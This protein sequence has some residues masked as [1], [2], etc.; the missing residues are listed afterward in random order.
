MARGNV[1]EVIIKAKDIAS[2]VVGRFR[3]TLRGIT[4]TAK[5]VARGIAA[6][7]AATAALVL[8]L[9]KVGERGSKVIAVKRT[10]AKITGDEVAALRRLREAS[11]NTIEDFQLMAL[12]NQ[13]LALG[14]AKTTEEFARQV[15]ISRILGR[16]QGI[17]ATEALQKLTVGLARMSRLRLDD[18]GIVLN[19]AEAD[20]RYAAA[21]GRS[22]ASL[23]D[24]EKKIAFRNEAMRQAEEL[25]GRLSAGEAGGTEATNRFSTA[26]ANLRDRLAEVTAESPLIA[27][28]FDQLTNV[29]SD[30][31]AIIGGDAGLMVD[32]MKTLG[33]L[34]GDAFSIGMNEAILAVTGGGPLGGVFDRFIQKEI[35]AARE[36]LT[37]NLA[38]LD[39]I[40]RAAE[41]QAEARRTAAEASRERAAAA[42]GGSMP[43]PSA[44][45]SALVGGFT[46]TEEQLRELLRRINDTQTALGDARLDAALAPTEEAAKR[47]GEE[48]EKLQEAL[49]GLNALA[50]QQGGIGGVVEALIGPGLDERLKRG[51]LPP[52]LI[53]PPGKLDIDPL[54]LTGAV[55]GLELASGVVVDSFANMADAAVSGSQRMEVAVTRSLQNII[56][57]IQTSGGGLFGGTLLG[58]IVGAGLGIVGSLFGG[59]NRQPVR[60]KVDDYSSTAE[61]KMKDAQSGPENVTIVIQQNGQTIEEIEYDLHRRQSRDAISRF[62]GGVSIQSGAG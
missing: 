5:D 23:T 60:V 20:E 58:G 21:L 22:A 55:E 41:A 3:R 46:G 52:A 42:R 30:M 29:L 24:S 14:S 40:A 7:T 8:G 2:S 18:L 31:I 15:N 27:E 59:R 43:P 10:F 62:P 47:A 61:R 45:G 25:V 13:A 39:S 37:A 50:D 51:L 28:L 32:G 49:E 33:R 11:R 54:E 9:T 44:G 6:L 26:M 4:R 17:E 16:A 36:N 12:L 38:A 1:V 56:A 48:V 57:N 19:Q 34:A 35:D 53:A